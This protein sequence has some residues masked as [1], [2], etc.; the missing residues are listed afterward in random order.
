MTMRAMAV[1]C[2]MW[3]YCN[4]KGNDDDESDGDD[5]DS[6]D[7]HNNSDCDDDDR[8]DDTANRE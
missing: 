1:S 6:V 8:S 4:K 5:V 3:K 7:W 2:L